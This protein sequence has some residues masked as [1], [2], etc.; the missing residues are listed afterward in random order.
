MPDRDWQSEIARMQNRD[1]KARG[2][3]GVS[4]TAD[5]AEIRRAFR[6]ASLALHPDV[7]GGAAG[8][9]RRFHLACCAY[10]WLTESEALRRFG[11]TRMPASA[12]HG[13]QVPFGQPL[14]LLVLVARQV[15]R[16]FDAGD[17]Q[18]QSMN[19]DAAGAGT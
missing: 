5:R 18:C 14:G 2:I 6:R 11:R 19:T 15:L 10:K 4:E 17:E 7:N 16:R 12:M 8:S 3:L 9:S 13:R 1:R